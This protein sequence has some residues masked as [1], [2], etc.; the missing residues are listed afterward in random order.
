MTSGEVK[1]ILGVISRK[2]ILRLRVKGK[3]SACPQYGLFLGFWSFVWVLG[4][5][6]GVLWGLPVLIGQLLTLVGLLLGS[7]K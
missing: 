1:I 2:V 7:T 4:F 6:S 5:V 3:T